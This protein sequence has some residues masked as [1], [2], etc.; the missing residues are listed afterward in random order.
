MA[1]AQIKRKISPGISAVENSG[2]AVTQLLFKMCN[3]KHGSRITAS[4]IK[5]QLN[6]FILKPEEPA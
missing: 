1:P 6:I 2:S 4:G 3:S 5:Q